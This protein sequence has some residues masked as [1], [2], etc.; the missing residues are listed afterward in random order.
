MEAQES[1]KS[2]TWHASCT[3]PLRRLHN[4]HHTE[5][6]VDSTNQTKIKKAH[7]TEKK[8]KKHIGCAP[9]L[10]SPLPPSPSININCSIHITAKH[11]KRQFSFGAQVHPDCGAFVSPCWKLTWILTHHPLQP[12]QPP[13]RCGHVSVGQWGQGMPLLPLPV[14]FTDGECRGTSQALCLSSE[15]GHNDCTLNLLGGGFL[16]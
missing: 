1:L 8:Q 10:H 13:Y 9:T 5:I 3:I 12:C 6:C 4:P 14:C 7:S 16:S 11:P 15:M 2:K